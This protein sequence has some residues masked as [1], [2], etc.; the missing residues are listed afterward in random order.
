MV[1]KANKDKIN[2]QMKELINKY[3]ERIVKLQQQQKIYEKTGRAGAC[4]TNQG[5]IQA[6][7]AVIK[8]LTKLLK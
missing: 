7:N 4:I 1:D 3:K 2:R 5:E 6:Y 8:D